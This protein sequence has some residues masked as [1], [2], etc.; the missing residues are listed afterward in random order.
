MHVYFRA[1]FTRVSG[2][3][4]VGSHQTESVYENPWGVCPVFVRLFSYLHPPFVI[5]FTTTPRAL[6]QC[7]HRDR[8]G[9]TFPINTWYD[10][11]SLRIVPVYIKR[12]GR[13]TKGRPQCNC[14]IRRGARRGT[15]RCIILYTMTGRAFIV[16]AD[17]CAV[18][19]CVRRMPHIWNSGRGEFP[20]VH[21]GPDATV[22]TQK[23]AAV[24][25]P[26]SA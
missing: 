24:A 14:S 11:T 12:T 26:E 4:F 20:G 21:R 2:I 9:T 19:I 16:I 7:L 6:R 15:G 17:I 23:L 10:K 8:S 13:C 18:Y 5:H 22:G 3:V 1:T 25:V